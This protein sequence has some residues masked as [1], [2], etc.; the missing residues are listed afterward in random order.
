M[1][2]TSDGRKTG[3]TP[4]LRALTNAGYS[5]RFEIAGRVWPVLYAPRNRHDPL[6]WVDAADV[7]R[8]SSRELVAVPE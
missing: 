1:K 4:E 7:Y 8:Y 5:V 6:P 2:T 3:S